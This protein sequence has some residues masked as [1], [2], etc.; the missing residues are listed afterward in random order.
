MVFLNYFKDLHDKFY[1]GVIMCFYISILQAVLAVSYFHVSFYSKTYK[2][3]DK[4]GWYFHTCIAFI[5]H[6][7]IPITVVILAVTLYLD[8]KNGSAAYN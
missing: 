2:C 1:K 7:V 5:L 3:W 8:T 4:V 6:I